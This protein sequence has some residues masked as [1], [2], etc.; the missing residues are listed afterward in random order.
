MIQNRKQIFLYKYRILRK[1]LIIKIS[2]KKLGWYVVF[3]VSTKKKKKNW[4][5]RIK[6]KTVYYG[7]YIWISLS[8][9]FIILR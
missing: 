7:T 2:E 3:Q 1:V 5:S 6:N 9:R 8:R 4:Q